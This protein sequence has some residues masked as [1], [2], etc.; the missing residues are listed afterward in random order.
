MWSDNAA[1]VDLLGYE[2]LLQ[3][4]LDLAVDD[5][6]QPLTIGAF[7]DWGAGKSTLLNLAGG[8]LRNQIGR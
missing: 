4:I 3:E 1:N 6:L 8:A 2:D 7:A 5:S